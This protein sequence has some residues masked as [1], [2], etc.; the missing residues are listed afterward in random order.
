MD[1]VDYVGVVGLSSINAILE[2]MAHAHILI[3]RSFFYTL[4]V[5]VIWFLLLSF[6]IGAAYDAAVDV[7]IF[8]AGYYWGAPIC[9]LLIIS[10][11][12]YDS[13]VERRRL[14]SSEE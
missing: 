8:D 10:L 14:Y 7:K 2:F 5:F 11:S 4:P 13:F 1:W 3:K 12:A 9:A 6:S